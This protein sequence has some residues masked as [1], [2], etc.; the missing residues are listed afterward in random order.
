MFELEDKSPLNSWPDAGLVLASPL[1]TAGMDHSHLL[2]L[3]VFS[4]SITISHD[5]ADWKKLFSQS[6][7]HSNK[8]RSKQSG[9]DLFCLVGFITSS[10]ATRLNCGRVPRLT[11]DNL[12]CRHTRDR[13]GRP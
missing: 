1:S 13:A 3:L 6:H 2:T 4:V 12:M 9:M 8:L 11:S 5:G 10:P 7:S